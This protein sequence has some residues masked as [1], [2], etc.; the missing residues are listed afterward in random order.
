MGVNLY[1]ENI[2]YLLF[3]GRMGKLVVFLYWILFVI[4]GNFFV[5]FLLGVVVVWW[6]CVYGVC[7]WVLLLVKQYCVKQGVELFDEN[8]VC[9]CLCLV[10]DYCGQW[11]LSCEFGFEF[12]VSGEE[13][14]VGCIVMYGYYFGVIEL[15]LYCFEVVVEVDNL[16]VYSVE[17]ICFDEWWQFWQKKVGD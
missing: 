8:V 17:V 3:V 6:W 10:C 13:C 7:E 15:V 16:L 11:W 9:W 14:Y 1:G 5:M 4:L 12:I 2:F